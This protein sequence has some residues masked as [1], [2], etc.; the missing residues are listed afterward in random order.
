MSRDKALITGLLS[1]EKVG[2][3]LWWVEK[4][5]LSSMVFFFSPHRKVLSQLESNEIS[6]HGFWV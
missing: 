3:L 5:G 1:A 6:T 2:S 4:L